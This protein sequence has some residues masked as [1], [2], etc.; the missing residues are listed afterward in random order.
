MNDEYKEL[1]E[2]KLDISILNKFSNDITIAFLKIKKK[3]SPWKFANR[4]ILQNLGTNNLT[5]GR[6]NIIKENGNIFR[7]YRLSTQILL[8]LKANLFTENYD[9]TVKNVAEYILNFN[10]GILCYMPIKAYENL[11]IQMIEKWII[12]DE[13]KNFKLKLDLDRLYFTQLNDKLCSVNLSIK[14]VAKY[15]CTDKSPQMNGQVLAIKSVIHKYILYFIDPNKYKEPKYDHIY[16]KYLTINFYLMFLIIKVF[17]LEIGKRKYSY[18]I[19]N[20][21]INNINIKSLF[22][23]K[24]FDY[25]QIFEQVKLYQI[26]INPEINNEQ[27]NMILERM[28]YFQ[29]DDNEQKMLMKIMDL[30]WIQI[31]N[32]YL[33]PLP[34]PFSSPPPPPFMNNISEQSNFGHVNNFPRQNNKRKI[35]NNIQFSSLKKQRH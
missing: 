1:K 16:M 31:D 27:Y 23:N 29:F 28:K 12:S 8:D 22:Y 5:S 6:F 26:K 9:N 19:N 21:N 32:F 18:F 34:L 24:L 3:N 4:I 20:I 15:K 17:D 30:I 33:S 2:K 35:P 10:K 25:N 14:N 11:S 13:F 7:T